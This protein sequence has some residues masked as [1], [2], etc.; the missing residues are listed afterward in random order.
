MNDRSA[1]EIRAWL[2]AGA[3]V[4]TGLLLF[5]RFSSN[6]RFAALVKV[7]PAK[8]RPLLIEKLCTLAG[9]APLQEQPR[10]TRRKFRDDFPFLRDPNCPPELKILAADKITAHDCYIRAHERLFDCTTL[11]ECYT[12]ARE[13]IENFIENR[14]IF[15]E[16][17]YYRE[18]G[19]VLGKHRIFEYLRRRQQLREMNIVDLLAEQR[20]LRS[21]IW[22]IDDE[23]KKGTKPHLQNERMQ[24]RRQKETLLDEVNKLIDAYT[25]AR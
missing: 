16:L 11:D 20:R 7:N 13:A 6:T 18:H 24:R 19:A 8:Y 1:E 10:P 17:D 14:A 12:T 5:S 4:K 21:A 15:Q 3:E 25:H 22:R 2:R 23:L 9:I